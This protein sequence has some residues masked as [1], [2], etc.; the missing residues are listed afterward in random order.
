MLLLGRFAIG[1]HNVPSETL[2]PVR[3]VHATH[4]ITTVIMRKGL[5][6]AP[7]ANEGGLVGTPLT[8]SV[9]VGGSPSRLEA[10]RCWSACW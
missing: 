5:A 9:A 6:F 8:A 10:A 2:E 3:A 4:T 1:Q 7:D